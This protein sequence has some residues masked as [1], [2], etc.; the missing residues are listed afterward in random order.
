M[1]RRAT[2]PPL[3]RARGADS[4]GGSLG[5]A[6]S[7]K[8]LRRYHRSQVLRYSPE[9]FTRVTGGECR[10]PE[11]R[12]GAKLDLGVLDAAAPP[13]MLLSSRSSTSRVG[14]STVTGAWT[15]DTIAAGAYVP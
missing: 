12:G 9:S 13:G 8:T 5:P 7:D 3:R 15:P 10:D 1:T 14:R 11:A 2:P 4:V 6:G